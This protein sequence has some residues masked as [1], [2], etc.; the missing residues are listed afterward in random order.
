[1]HWL[2]NYWYRLSPL[3]LV[4]WPLSVLFGAVAALRRFCYRRGIC[5]SSAPGVPVIIVGNINVGGTGK[6]PCV[7][8]L[9][10]RLLDH[11]YKP[12]VVTRGYGGSAHEPQRA[13]TAS[14]PAAIGDEAVLLARRCD[15]PVWVARSRVA[16]AQALRTAHPECNVIISDD[17]LQHYALRRNVEI[18]VLDGERGCGNGMLL[19]AGP[20]RESLRRLDSVDAIVINGGALFPP[21]MLPSVV[22]T[23]DMRLAGAAFYSLH[24]AGHAVP[25]TYFAKMDVHA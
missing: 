10:R 22:P 19:P 18:V 23:F 5:K 13:A 2:E 7:I 16:A 14:D 3:H 6:T 21:E 20:L 25:A 9:V 15:C 4:L 8:W 11:G 17:G 1:M 12:G 24:T